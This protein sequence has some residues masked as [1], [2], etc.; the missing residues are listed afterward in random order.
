MPYL[1]KVG[2]HPIVNNLTDIDKSNVGEVPT[3]IF[4]TL[5]DGETEVKDLKW[6]VIGSCE[7][8]GESGKRTFFLVKIEEW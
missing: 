2:N 1:F 8:D 6:D 5:T 4:R 7:A 3:P